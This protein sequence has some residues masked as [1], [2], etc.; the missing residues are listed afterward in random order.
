MLLRAVSPSTV[1]SGP[2]GLSN[3][4]STTF[5]DMV[6]VLKRAHRYPENLVIDFR[7]E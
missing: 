3:G 4:R 7:H 5:G 6:A 2:N 1:S